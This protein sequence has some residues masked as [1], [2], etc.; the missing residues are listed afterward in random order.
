MHDAAKNAASP[1]VDFRL[2]TPA[3]DLKL[4][5]FVIGCNSPAFAP[6]ERRTVRRNVATSPV[7]AAAA[8]YSVGQHHPG[9]S[10]LPLR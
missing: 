1:I 8:D 7:T 3:G 6:C 4:G 10:D 5:F 2:F 9:T